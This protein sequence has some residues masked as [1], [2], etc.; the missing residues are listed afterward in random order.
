ME[1]V[2]KDEQ[3]PT[4]DISKPGNEESKSSQDLFLEGVRRGER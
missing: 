4:I 2:S 3:A 1:K